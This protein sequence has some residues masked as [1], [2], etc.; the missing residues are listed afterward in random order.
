VT[1]KRARPAAFR[2]L[3]AGAGI[4][5]ALLAALL[6]LATRLADTKEF[7]DFA[8]AKLE[9]ATGVRLSCARADVSLFP[10]PRVVAREVSFDIAGVAQGTVSA[11]TVEPMPAPLLRGR[12]LVRDLLLENPKLAV[13]IPRETKPAKALSGEEIEKALSSLL[14]ALRAKAPGAIL[15]VRNG[16][17]DL[18]GR[19]GAIVS[20]RG[21]DA[22]L[23]LPPD[24]L[25]LS[26]R[27]ASEHWET[28]TVDLTLRP[29]GLLGNA[30]VEATRFRPGAFVERLA[31]GAVPRLGEAEL[32]LAGR[33]ASEGLR[34]VKAEF[35]GGAPS[36]AIRRSAR[37]RTFRAVSFKGSAEWTDR[38]FRAALVDLSIDDPRVRLSGELSREGGPA[39]LVAR[40]RGQGADI[41]SIR[42]AAL[43]LAGDLPAVRH[44]FDI[45]RGGALSRF[46]IESRGNSLRDL[47]SLGSLR[48]RATLAGGTI[49]VPGIDP[50]LKGAGGELSLS[51]GIL[52]GKGLAARLGKSVAREGTLRLGIAGEDAPFRLSCLADADLGELTPI[53]RR[54]APDGGFRGEID[55][56]REVRGTV[57]GRLTLGDRLSSIRTSVVLTGMDFSGRYDRIPFPV[58]VRGGQAS[59]DEDG[60]SVTDLRGSVGHSTVSALTGRLSFGK[61]PSIS[62]RGGRIRA[63]L[64][65]LFPRIASLDGARDALKEFT[66]VRGTAA[67]SSL[68]V[69]GPLWEPAKWRFEAEG[70]VEG[71]KAAASPLPGPV[72]V[73]RGRFRVTPEEILLE[74]VEASLADTTLR[75]RLS[76][77]GYRDGVARADASLKGTIG[78]ASANRAYAR[79]GAWKLLAPEAPFAVAGSTLSWRK[80]GSFDLDA[81][82]S[83]PEGPVLSL[84]LRKGPGTLTID[85]L[86]VR[87]GDSDARASLRVDPLAARVT[88]A[89]TLSSSTVEAILPFA[90]MPG[91]RLRGDVEAVLDRRRPAR[92]TARGTLDVSDF[93]VPWK[94]LAPLVIRSA[95]LSADGRTVRVV[96]SDLLWDNVP[97]TL[98]GTA[99]TGGETVVADL[100]LSAGDIDVPKLMRSIVPESAAADDIAPAAAPREGEAGASSPASGGFPVRGVL[101]FRADSVSKW[102]L[103]WRPLRGTADIDDRGLRL[104]ISEADLCGI[105]TPGSLTLD[106][107]GPSVVLTASTSG[108]DLDRAAACISGRHVSVTGTYGLSVRVE[109]TGMG[110]EL[111]RSFRGPVSLTARDGRIHRMHL[112][113]VL[114]TYL[115]VAE[116]FRWKLPDLG[117]EG[118]P[119]RTLTVR[120]EM[121]DGKI[122]VKEAA[123]DAPSMGI[124]AT[125]EVD[126]LRETVDFQVL[127]APF[128]TADAVIRRIPI[129]RDILNRTL[130]SI[131]VTVKGDIRN[132]TVTPLNPSAVE[133]GLLGIVERTLEIPA[134]LLSPILPG[135]TRSR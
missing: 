68:S 98:T 122:L 78:A 3:L 66:D 111:V 57:S 23:A 37:N 77:L 95:S 126:L 70:S 17:I 91:H 48:A 10:R 116:L 38:S 55:R 134:R 44:V 22:R 36:L 106:S 71:L 9:R 100:D 132:P 39:P 25:K 105:S 29:E 43:A 63:A 130:V 99:E 90:V 33:I 27:C 110:D 64:E 107:A 69:E 117:E 40:L 123:I 61:T 120:G 4:L 115:N 35:A 97:F 81:G 18:S 74:D 133:K 80:D 135:K 20:L 101:R 83:W 76:L 24:R 13:R 49:A 16:R 53:L 8:L 108:K 113:S 88:F 50:P 79:F 114:L 6:L 58:S 12:L 94:P 59:I 31:P 5:A 75:G 127:V 60:L 121:R 21:L 67:L 96:S 62:I 11:L 41:P 128:R 28:L 84:S 89:G 129:V 125:G 73:P 46:S 109:G 56:I 93:A 103:T 87:D 85:P 72:A 86:V 54:L 7:R 1:G 82:L 92:S 32:S 30:R 14:A 65:E 47:P 45:V 51:G 42:A 26:A 102:G 104:A 15:A 2:F 124:A 34:N 19:E 112:L 119:Y 52:E 131:P 118:F